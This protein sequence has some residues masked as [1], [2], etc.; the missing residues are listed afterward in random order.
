MPK[1]QKRPHKLNYVGV[2]KLSI[3]PNLLNC[4]FSPSTPN[5]VWV[6]V[7][8]QIPTDEGWLYLAVVK[9]CH[10]CEIVGWVIA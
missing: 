5:Q 10:T 7:I 6:A 2:I 9:D 1:S 8:T 4:Q 3:A